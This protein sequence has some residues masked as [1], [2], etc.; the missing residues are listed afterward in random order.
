MG[1]NQ[2]RFGLILQSAIRSQSQ[3]EDPTQL[4]WQQTQSHKAM[5]GR[6][7]S[8]NHEISIS[9]L[10][11]HL[12]SATISDSSQLNVLRDPLEPLSYKIESMIYIFSGSG[13]QDTQT[14]VQLRQFGCFLEHEVQALCPCTRLPEFGYFSFCPPYGTNWF[15]NG[16]TQTHTQ[17][18]DLT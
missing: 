2:P 14:L 7:S 16:M 4:T 5:M 8:K 17:N 1:P 6:V 18:I 15:W 3:R 12:I 11:Q 9:I 13:F 10:I